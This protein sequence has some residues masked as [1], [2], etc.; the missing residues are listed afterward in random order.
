MIA[1][2]WIT[3]LGVYYASYGHPIIG[4]LLIV[5]PWYLHTLKGRTS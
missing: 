3:I 2:L 1:P 5:G 4:G